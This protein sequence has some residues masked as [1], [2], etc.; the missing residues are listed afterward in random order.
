MNSHRSGGLVT[1]GLVLKKTIGAVAA[2]EFSIV[3]PLGSLGPD[4]RPR[5]GLV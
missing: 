1:V 5:E 2:R 3:W 4:L